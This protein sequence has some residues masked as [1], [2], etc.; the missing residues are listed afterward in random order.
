MAVDPLTVAATVIQL[1]KLIA[2]TT[3]AFRK[4]QAG[5]LTDLDWLEM[6]EGLA[7]A[8]ADWYSA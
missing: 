4:A 3:E 8:D 7:A 2:E 5:E 1:G 6:R